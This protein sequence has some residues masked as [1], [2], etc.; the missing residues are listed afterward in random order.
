MTTVQEEIR[1]FIETESGF[2]DAQREAYLAR[3]EVLRVINAPE[4]ITK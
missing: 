4:L 2:I 1:R 3:I